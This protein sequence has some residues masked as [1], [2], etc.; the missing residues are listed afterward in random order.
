MVYSDRTNSEGKIFIEKLEY[1]K[2]Y[3]IEKEAP[4]G[5]ILNDSKHYFE[6]KENGEVVKSTL[7]D[8][9]IKGNLI[10]HKTDEEGNF[11]EGVVINVY[12][13]DGTLYGTYTTNQ[14]GIVVIEDM[15]YGDYAIK[16]VSTID[17]YELSS[18]T[19][20]FSITENGEELNITMVNTK[21]PQTDM[22]DNLTLISL[23][24]IVA[25][26]MIYLATKCHSKKD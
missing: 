11:L 17:G 26:S 20:N 5:Y 9:R 23:A 18:E 2:Y 22:N 19:I 25:G 6:I 3:F 12:L 7:K 8:E 1:G 13:S 14:D 4:E 15:E 24:L 10:F 21:L 16:E